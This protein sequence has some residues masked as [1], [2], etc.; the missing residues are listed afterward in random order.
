MQIEEILEEVNSIQEDVTESK[1]EKAKAEGILSE[2]IKAL[3]SLCVK[4]EAEGNKKVPKV[5][6]ELEKL[7]ELIIS[8]FEKLSE[9]YEW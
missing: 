2:H 1:Q 9:S 8:K 5:K 3:K 7:K 4:S 6:K